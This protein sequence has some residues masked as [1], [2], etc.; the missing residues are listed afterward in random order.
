MQIVE[1]TPPWLRA[2]GPLHPVAAQR[3]LGDLAPLIPDCHRAKSLVARLQ[4]MI[5]HHRMDRTSV[6]PDELTAVFEEL[7][8]LGLSIDAQV[9]AL[10]F[11]APLE[12]G[13]L[14]LRKRYAASGDLV[15]EGDRAEEWY[16]DPGLMGQEALAVLDSY[17][18]EAE[19]TVKE[20][21]AQAYGPKEP[22][23]EVAAG[24]ECKHSG[25]FN[26]VVWYGRPF[27][28]TKRQAEVVELLWRAW[29]SG[30]PGL[31]QDYIGE[32][33]APES[34]R[35]S[36]SDL[37]RVEYKRPGKTKRRTKS[38]DAMGYMIHR[39]GPGIWML[40]PPQQT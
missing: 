7:C 28:F 40:G 9:D 20:L 39:Q 27:E 38:H 24:P 12:F 5:G 35:F 26:S 37:F 31:N 17:I 11:S 21:E 16:V 30:T 14:F 22:A 23:P 25:T 6:S 19:A 2:P 1:Q 32:R 13:S 4:R 10:Y 3:L 29:E 15:V 34:K 18:W 36:V 8:C 33:V